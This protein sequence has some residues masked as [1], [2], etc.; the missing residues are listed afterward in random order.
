[1]NDM[2]TG[3]QNCLSIW[4]D[5]ILNKKNSF[6]SHLGILEDVAVHSM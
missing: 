3:P 2:A 4:W 6:R 1:M 5:E